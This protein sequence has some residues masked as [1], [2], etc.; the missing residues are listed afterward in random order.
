MTWKR[1]AALEMGASAFDVAVHA[2]GVLLRGFD[3]V[4]GWDGASRE[5]SW[6]VRLPKDQAMSC[7]QLAR[8]GDVFA[9]VE[10]PGGAAAAQ[11]I[12]LRSDGSVAWRAPLGLNVELRGLTAAR[13]RIWATGGTGKRPELVAVDATSGRIADRLPAP[14]DQLASAGDVVVVAGR[15]GLWMLG[16][17]GPEQVFE[18]ANAGELLADGTDVY[19]YF[20]DP[21]ESYA[22]SIGRL[23]ARTGRVTAT[24]VTPDDVE[25]GPCSPRA[26]VGAGVVVSLGSGRGVGLFDLGGGQVVW[27]ALGDAGGTVG[28]CAASGG[29]LVCSL[30]L[31]KVGRMA[32]LDTKGVA[33]PLPPAGA[34][35]ADMVLSLGDDVLVGGARLL[36]RFSWSRS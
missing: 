19:F 29:I 12:G 20:E 16:D 9:A 5:P 28:R 31:S 13:D 15:K 26:R 4:V 18:G 36:E 23:D 21:A 17:G 6:S 10:D 33:A 8:S 24:L 7:K 3:R 1:I 35:D 2:S 14:G 30:A 22:P 34:P 11:M 27:R 25:E 32:A